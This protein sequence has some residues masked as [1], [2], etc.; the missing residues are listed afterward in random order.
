MLL[1]W[2]STKMIKRKQKNKMLKFIE[3]CLTIIGKMLWKIS[4]LK[5][6]ILTQFKIINI[7]YFMLRICLINLMCMLKMKALMIY[8]VMVF[9]LLKIKTG[10]LLKR[11]QD[12]KNNM[13]IGFVVLYMI[14]G[15]N[16]ITS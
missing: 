7:C 10:M 8:N 5:L 13:L 12:F 11:I 2:L 9:I 15:K 6:L 3:K 1:L 14:N 4:L 16:L